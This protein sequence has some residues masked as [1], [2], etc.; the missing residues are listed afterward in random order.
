MDKEEVYVGDGSCNGHVSDDD[1]GYIEG[2]SANGSEK[3]DMDTASVSVATTTPRITATPLDDTR[4]RLH[5]LQPPSSAKPRYRPATECVFIENT[6]VR[7]PYNASSIPIYMTATFKQSSSSEMGEYDYSRSGNP[8][9]THL[10]TFG[11]L[12]TWRI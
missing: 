7:D 10:G 1:S 8:T 11:G 12:M 3:G 4:N 6:G 2:S 5:V 9:R